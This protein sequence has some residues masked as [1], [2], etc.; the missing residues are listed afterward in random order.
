MFN[1]KGLGQN[2]L[3]NAA[4]HVSK[5]EVAAA[6]SV[7][8]AFVVDAHEMQHGGVKVGTRTLFSCGKTKL[9]RGSIRHAA[10]HPGR[11]A[12]KPW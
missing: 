10:A 9:I 3:H 2:L 11:P 6:V 5:A 7:G 8:K 12:P 4:M 1:D